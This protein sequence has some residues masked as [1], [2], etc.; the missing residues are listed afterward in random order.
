MTSDYDPRARRLNPEIQELVDILNEHWSAIVAETDYLERK[1][2]LRFIR[3]V[4]DQIIEQPEWL[5]PDL[6]DGAVEAVGCWFDPDEFAGEAA[7][8]F[9]D[10][11]PFDTPGPSSSLCFFYADTGMASPLYE[12]EPVDPFLGPLR[13]HGPY[14]YTLEKTFVTAVETA[15]HVISGNLWRHVLPEADS[16]A[17]TGERWVLLCDPRGLGGGKQVLRVAAFDDPGLATEIAESLS[18]QLQIRF[19]VALERRRW[20]T[21]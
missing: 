12:G 14:V 2:K 1:G 18:E 19:L 20:C 8:L 17:A 13:N 15:A 7:P 9:L 3:Q 21:R 11:K 6:Q 16:A 10:E 4:I 5:E